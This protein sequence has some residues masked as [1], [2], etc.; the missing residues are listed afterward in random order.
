MILAEQGPNL[1]DRF[2]SDGTIAIMKGSP[3]LVL[4]NEEKGKGVMKKKERIRE[5]TRERVQ[6]GLILMIA[7]GC[8]LLALLPFLLGTIETSTIVCGDVGVGRSLNIWSA[9]GQKE[10]YHQSFTLTGT[11]QINILRKESTSFI[12]TSFNTFVEALGFSFRKKLIFVLNLESGRVEDQYLRIQL[13]LTYLPLSTPY[14]LVYSRVS[15]KDLKID[16]GKIHH[17]YL[18][19]QPAGYLLTKEYDKQDEA[20]KLLISKE[21]HAFI[22]NAESFYSSNH[23]RGLSYRERLKL[24]QEKHTDIKERLEEIQQLEVPNPKD[25][26]SKSSKRHKAEIEKENKLIQEHLEKNPTLNSCKFESK[27]EEQPFEETS[28][29]QPLNSF[30]KWRPVTVIRTTT[31]KGILRTTYAR[32]VCEGKFG[33]ITSQD[34]Q[35]TGKSRIVTFNQTRRPHYFGIAQK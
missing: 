11:Q 19:I 25:I 20:S 16:F 5:R 29:H 3:Y 7:L 6:I 10:L 1:H 34:W 18:T 4:N 8:I 13:A 28:K 15:S 14:Y 30:Y 9:S 21:I 33:V 24:V 35:E 12:E 32:M 22:E 23:F 17:Q 31:E 2:Y 26:T 27:V